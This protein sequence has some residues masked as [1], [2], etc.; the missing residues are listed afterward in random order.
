MESVKS[1]DSTITS[2]ELKELYKDSYTI[3]ILYQ[4][5]QKTLDNKEVENIRTKILTGLKEKYGISDKKEIMYWDDR[6]YSVRNLNEAGFNGQQYKDH[7]SFK[8]ILA[9]YGCQV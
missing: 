7:K 1:S 2:V 8:D 4:D 3:R 9:G 5:P 6:E